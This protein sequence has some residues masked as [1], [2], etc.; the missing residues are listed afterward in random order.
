M[1]RLIKGLIVKGDAFDRVGAL[2]SLV[3]S[4]SASA[5]G[6]GIPEIDTLLGPTRD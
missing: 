1:A 3:N 6:W 2:V 4:L 5:I